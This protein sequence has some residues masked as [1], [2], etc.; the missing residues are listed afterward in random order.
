MKDVDQLDKVF[1][2]LSSNKGNWDIWK[3]WEQSNSKWRSLQDLVV[4]FLQ[5]DQQLWPKL[6]F[7]QLG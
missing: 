6:G 1:K 4:Y 7:R 5:E 3:I 2:I